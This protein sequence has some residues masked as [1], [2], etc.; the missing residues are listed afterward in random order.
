MGVLDGVYRTLMTRNSVY[1][2]FVI[3]GALAGERAVNVG[4]DY[5][6]NAN[7]KGKLFDHLVSSSLAEGR[8][9]PKPE[10]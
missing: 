6:W 10:E 5:A 1:V 7:N 9:F 3:A 2:T 4:V 8:L